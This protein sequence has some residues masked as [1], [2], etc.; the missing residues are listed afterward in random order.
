MT[1]AGMDEPEL[2]ESDSDALA[3]FAHYMDEKGARGI[4]DR[5]PVDAI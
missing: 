4:L 1:A 3:A 5:A 2:I